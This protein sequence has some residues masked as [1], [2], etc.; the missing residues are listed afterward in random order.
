MFSRVIF[1]LSF[2][3]E[4][5]DTNKEILSIKISEEVGYKNGIFLGHFFLMI[6]R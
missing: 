3:V 1:S 6:G 2:S 5:G 4:R